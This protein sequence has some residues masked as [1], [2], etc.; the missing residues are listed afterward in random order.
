MS[1]PI[2]IETTT[3]TSE[4]LVLVPP[5]AVAEPKPSEFMKP[6]CLVVNTREARD[7]TPDDL[8]RGGYVLRE[9][10]D[11]YSQWADER[12]RAEKAEG[13]LIQRETELRLARED[14]ASVERQM[15][16]AR[17]AADASFVR[18]NQAEARAEKAERERDTWEERCRTA[19]RELVEARAEL[20]RLTAPGEGA[21][22][23]CRGELGVAHERARQQ[24]TQTPAQATGTHTF[25]GRMATEVIP[26]EPAKDRAT[27]TGECAVVRTM[28]KAAEV[29][30]TLARL[31]GEVARG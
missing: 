5:S 27:A 15:R 29:P 14:G 31:L 6:G 17:S 3:T 2:I 30:A 21:C 7:A 18:A 23:A 4:R 22:W 25:G 19:S 24:P 9:P 20:A 13:L 12:A 16:E 8:A 10:G 28:R 1:E 26:S 11:Y